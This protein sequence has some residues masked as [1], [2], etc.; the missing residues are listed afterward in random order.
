MK[1]WMAKSGGHWV[2]GVL[3]AVSL[4]CAPLNS[5]A[6]AVNYIDESGNVHFADSVDQVPARYR[7]Q[8][9]KKK[10]AIVTLEQYKQAQ[11]E[12]RKQQ[13]ELKR[14]QKQDEKIAQK[15]AKERAKQLEKVKK[16]EEARAK[17]LED[18]KEA[19][20]KQNAAQSARA[21]GAAHSKAMDL[22]NDQE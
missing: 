15:L 11:K 16:E 3:G 10:P 4:W 14:K 20:A 9:Q 13:Q 19:L 17:K 12:F 1:K 18:K 8:V 5:Y 6:Q 21:K 2:L 22:R 7:D